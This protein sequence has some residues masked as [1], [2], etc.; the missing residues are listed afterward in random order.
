MIDDNTNN[1]KKIDIS[2]QR[3]DSLRTGVNSSQILRVM[4]SQANEL[5][6]IEISQP[7]SSYKCLIGWQ[8]LKNRELNSIELERDSHVIFDSEGDIYAIN[9]GQ[10]IDL[11]KQVRMTCFKTKYLTNQE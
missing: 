9:N 6:A 5:I 8:V 7:N 3:P 2:I 11:R 4:T 1:F 10:V